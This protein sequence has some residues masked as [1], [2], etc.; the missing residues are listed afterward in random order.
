M[1]PPGTLRQPRSRGTLAGPCGSSLWPRRLGGTWRGGLPNSTPEGAF[2][3]LRFLRFPPALTLPVLRLLHLEPRER[4]ALAVGRGFILPDQAL[5]PAL[6]H[7][8]PGLEP[9]RSQPARREDELLAVDFLLE[10]QPGRWKGRCPS[11]AA[12]GAL[13]IGRGAATR[14]SIRG[15]RLAQRTPAGRWPILPG[16]RGSSRHGIVSAHAPRNGKDQ[17]RAVC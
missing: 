7:L 1:K 15:G 8:G 9:V 3:G 16:A 13:T 10:D 5:V 14:W 11:V 6:E 17:I 4:P 2:G 12:I